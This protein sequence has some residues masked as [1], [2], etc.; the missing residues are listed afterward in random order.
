MYGLVVMVNAD[1]IIIFLFYKYLI[2]MIII[3]IFLFHNI[4]EI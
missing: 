1:K 4:Y 3:A 2:A